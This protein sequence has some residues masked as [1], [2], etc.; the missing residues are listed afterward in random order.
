MLC[1]FFIA[2]ISL[3]LSIAPCFRDAKGLHQLNYESNISSTVYIR[4]QSKIV[5]DELHPVS[6]LQNQAAYHYQVHGL[7][8]LESVSPSQ[9]PS[10][11]NDNPKF[12]LQAE[13]TGQE[14]VN[15]SCTFKV[16][17]LLK[18]SADDNIALA[19]SAISGQ[20]H[21]KEPQ[22]DEQS[23]DISYALHSMSALHN[24]QNQMAL[25]P[26]VDGNSLC[27]VSGVTTNS[28]HSSNPILNLP[29]KTVDQEPIPGHEKLT[30]P[31]K[32]EDQKLD[33]SFS[34]SQPTRL[35]QSS[36]DDHIAFGTQAMLGQAKLKMPVK[37]IDQEQENSTSS[38]ET[39]QL[40]DINCALHSDDSFSA[41]H[42]LQNQMVF[43]PKVDGRGGGGLVIVRQV[44]S[45][46]NLNVTSPKLAMPDKVIVQEQ[47]STLLNKSADN[48]IELATPAISGSG[49]L[50]ALPKEPESILQAHLVS[51]F[52]LNTV[53]GYALQQEAM[54]Q[55]HLVPN[56]LQQKTAKILPDSDIRVYESKLESSMQAQHATFSIPLESE[57]PK[58]LPKTK[59]PVDESQAESLVRAQLT[60]FA[61]P[62]DVDPPRNLSEQYDI[63]RERQSLG[64]GPQYD[65][66]LEREH[67]GRGPANQSAQAASR[68]N[69]EP[70]NIATWVLHSFGIR[71]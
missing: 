67:V 65:T 37:T 64:G 36:P 9:I 29:I 11:P 19:T 57:P 34:T 15:S 5:S 63:P 4:Q 14:E 31:V 32:M 44:S 35:L 20:Q 2:L 55:E 61:N 62:S 46:P 6:A 25:Q 52:A 43:P 1:C 26:E 12:Y 10:V 7:G 16:N 56:P 27:Y 30:M 51:T 28:N 58:T 40:A 13:L 39:K 50:H 42:N 45:V 24:F 69:A 38:L 53:K 70:E 66:T 21:H 18:M 60:W 3:L 71:F 22:N 47:G 49:H 23:V 68:S 41:L 59:F 17:T 8:G 48:S 54:E 33:N